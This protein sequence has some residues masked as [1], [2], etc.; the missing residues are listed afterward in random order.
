[1]AKPTGNNPGRPRTF[2]RETAL[3]RALGVFWKRGYEPASIAELC[4]AMGINA[5]SLYAAFGNKAKLFLEAVQYYENVYWD[6]VWDKMEE[7]PDPYKAIP[8]FFHTAASILTSQDTPCGCLV[9]L[10][11]TNISPESREVSEA[12]RA[13]R[14]EGKDLFLR[15]VE[16]AVSD[17]FFPP[18]TN[19]RMIASALNTFLEGMS[20]QSSDGISQAELQ[21][22]ASLVSLML[23]P[24]N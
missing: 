18:D 8:D 19:T 6:A 1:M 20:I 16:K 21:E 23:P 11:A 9:V 17:G 12:L 22:T 13:M 2:D 3:N 24:P 4:S 15:R 14:Q 10:A 7:E 5:P